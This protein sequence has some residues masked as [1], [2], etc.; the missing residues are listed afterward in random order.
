MRM[1]PVLAAEEAL[2]GFTITA[3]GSSNIKPQSTKRLIRMWERAANEGAPIENRSTINFNQ[4]DGIN[5]LR[6]FVPVR[7]ITKLE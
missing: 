5:R 3:A 4:Q 1:I 6:K 2:V 7:Q